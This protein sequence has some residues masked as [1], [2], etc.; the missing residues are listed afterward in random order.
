[1][2]DPAADNVDDLL[3]RFGPRRKERFAAV[4]PHRLLI[5][6]LRRKG[7]SFQTIFQVLKHKGIETSTTRVRAFCREVLNEATTME[8]QPK[9]RTSERRKASAT[10]ASIAP[11]AHPIP[12][13]PP[14]NSPPRGQQSGP[15]IANVEFIQEPKI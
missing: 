5:E 12:P 2:T 6:E 10:A 1:M 11:Q 9:R 13:Q 8:P 4:Q 3:T 15:R 14:S 7:A